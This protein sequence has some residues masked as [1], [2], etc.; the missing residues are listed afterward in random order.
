MARVA[1]LIS[2][3]SSLLLNSTINVSEFVRLIRRFH[4]YPLED[5]NSQHIHM[6]V[7]SSNRLV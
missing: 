3:T 1:Y 6:F 5:R 2:S 7:A 4:N